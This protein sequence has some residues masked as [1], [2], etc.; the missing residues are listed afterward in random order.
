[1]VKALVVYLSAQELG[2]SGSRNMLKVGLRIVVERVKSLARD[3]C[4]AAGKM[5][6]DHSVSLSQI[7]AV[8]VGSH[9]CGVGVEKLR[10]DYFFLAFQR[11]SLAGALIG[12]WTGF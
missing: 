3:S 4:I 9:A 12:T 1:M 11:S 5:V 8:S 10:T 6:Y 7:L 2:A